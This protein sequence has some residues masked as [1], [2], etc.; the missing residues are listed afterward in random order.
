LSGVGEFESVVKLWENFGVQIIVLS[1]AKCGKLFVMKWQF[2]R[3][4]FEEGVE[5]LMHHR[6]GNIA[7]VLNGASCF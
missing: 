3:N 7:C 5:Y 6:T 2:G 1:C 4:L